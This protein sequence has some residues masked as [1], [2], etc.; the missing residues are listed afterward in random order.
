MVLEERD[1]VPDRIPGSGGRAFIM[2]LLLIL[3]SCSTKIPSDTG[4]RELLLEGAWQLEVI[5]HENSCLHIGDPPFSAF[6]SGD[7]LGRFFS[8]D[9]SGRMLL[10]STESDVQSI[11]HRTGIVSDVHLVE[12]GY[13]HLY[14]AKETDLTCSDGSE[15]SFES[16]ADFTGQIL[17]NIELSFSGIEVLDVS[18]TECSAELIECR[19]E[20]ELLAYWVEPLAD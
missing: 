1:T 4:D 15:I 6:S 9:S 3:I 19:Y 14:A 2:S 8:I 13:L 16:R 17:S 11:S 20:G 18:E 10:T 7:A 5:R 12:E